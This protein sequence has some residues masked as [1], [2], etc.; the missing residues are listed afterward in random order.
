[1]F[2]QKAELSKPGPS[3]VRKPHEAFRGAANHHP[4]LHSPKFDIGSMRAVTIFS[5]PGIR[6]GVEGTRPI[7]LV[8]IAPTVAHALGIPPPAQ[9]EGRVLRGIF[10]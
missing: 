4:F 2:F 9:T 10:E 5:G 6:K 1:V 7:N 8:D 3:V